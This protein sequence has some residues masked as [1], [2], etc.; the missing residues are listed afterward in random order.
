MTRGRSIQVTCG[1]PGSD[2]WQADLDFW[3]YSWANPKVTR[4]TTG[5]VTR[6]TDDVSI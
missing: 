1:S 4:V 2:T 6:G 5:R 3:A